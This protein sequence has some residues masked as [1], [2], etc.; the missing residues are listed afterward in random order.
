M[1]ISR[2]AGL[3]GL[4]VLALLAALLIQ[5]ATA[6]EGE[7]DAKTLF[8][9]THKCNMCHGVPAVGIEAKTKSESMKG[10]ELGGK[11]KGDFAKIA[12]YMR[13][14]TEDKKHKKEFKGTDEELQ[15]ILDWLGSL[16][17]QE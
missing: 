6:A 17:A 13:K 11:V 7:K 12:A 9:E 15:T 1:R 3:A 14:E 10:P 2:F 5:P 4:A 16:E 8:V